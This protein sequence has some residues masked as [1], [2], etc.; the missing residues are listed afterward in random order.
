MNSDTA[1]I[2]WLFIAFEFQNF[3]FCISD[4]FTNNP[5]GMNGLSR[6]NNQTVIMITLNR[7]CMPLV[8]LNEFP[9]SFSLPPNQPPTTAPPRFSYKNN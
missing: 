5:I 8:Q 2:R 3:L 7:S 4:I 6:R 1:R 9:L